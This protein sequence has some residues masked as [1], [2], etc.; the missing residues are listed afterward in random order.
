MTDLGLRAHEVA[1]ISLDDIDWRT[2]ILRLPSSTKARRASILPLPV[3]VGRAIV[4][5]LRDGRPITQERRIFVRHI[6]P[7]GQRINSEAVR[8]VIRRAFKRAHINIPSNGSHILRHTVA[9][10]MIRQGASL[11]EIADV[12]RHRNL[13]RP[14]YIPK[15]ICQHSLKSPC[16]GRRCKDESK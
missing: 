3:D 6:R 10:R 5:Y 15:W 2:G 9:T 13:T 16:P 4:A 12:L 14:Q 11:K 1:S 8:A 7:V